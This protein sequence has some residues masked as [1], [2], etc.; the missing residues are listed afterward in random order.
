MK[1]IKYNFFDVLGFDGNVMFV[2]LVLLW[3]P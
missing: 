2:V 3:K 1:S